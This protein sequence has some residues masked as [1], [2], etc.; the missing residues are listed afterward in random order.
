MIS[1]NCQEVLYLGQT[2]E[3]KMHDKKIADEEGCTF[4][5]GFYLRQDLGYQGYSPRGVHIMQPFKK[6]R[7]GELTDMQKWYNRLVATMRIPAEHA[8]NGIKRC[9]IVK[10]KCRHFCQQ[11]RDEVMWICTGLH[12]FRV[13]SPYRDYRSV[14]T[15]A[16]A[17]LQI[18]SE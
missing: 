10:D 16:H 6:P 3:G 13:R 11:F 9:R 4:P 1:A 15:W 8:I 2:H 7:N 18:H 12:N 14:R 17:R 5:Q